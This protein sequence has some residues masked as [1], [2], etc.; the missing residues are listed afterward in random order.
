MTQPNTFTYRVYHT[1]IGIIV[2][3]NETIFLPAMTPNCVSMSDIR[4]GCL[5]VADL[6]SC[7][8]YKVS[9]LPFI[10]ALLRRGWNIA[11]TLCHFLEILT[12]IIRSVGDVIIGFAHTDKLFKI[13]GIHISTISVHPI[14][15]RFLVKTFLY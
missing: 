6:V 10:Y 15:F 7:N 1:Q 4:N 14:S 3:L 5:T 13:S 11:M 9:S 8:R 2:S 12:M